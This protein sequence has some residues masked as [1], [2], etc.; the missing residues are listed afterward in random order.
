MLF[1]MGVACSF[2]VEFCV[3]EIVG[4]LDSEVGVTNVTMSLA[5]RDN[6]A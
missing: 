1:F 6:Y 2:M 5:V 3:I 4:Q